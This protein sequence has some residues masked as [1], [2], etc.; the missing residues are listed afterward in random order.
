MENESQKQLNAAETK[1]LET[2]CIILSNVN[3]SMEP[4]QLEKSL[5]HIEQ[6]L[7]IFN[8]FQRITN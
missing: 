4:D 2:A 7:R 1:A 3:A 6:L 8:E 5:N